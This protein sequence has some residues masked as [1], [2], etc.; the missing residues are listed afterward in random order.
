MSWELRQYNGYSGNVKIWNF[1]EIENKK[2]TF[3]KGLEVWQK[4]SIYK[5]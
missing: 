4:A 5:C 3:K 1:I 2:F